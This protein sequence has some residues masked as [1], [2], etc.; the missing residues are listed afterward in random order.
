MLGCA[1]A[2]CQKTASRQ[3]VG[4]LGTRYN[5]FNHCFNGNFAATPSPISIAASATFER[6]VRDRYGLANIAHVSLGFARR[7]TRADKRP[8]R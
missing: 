7:S 8:R 4:S 1:G 2:K 6:A 5:V 3:I